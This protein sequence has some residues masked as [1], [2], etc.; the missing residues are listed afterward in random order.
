MLF[1]AGFQRR[2]RVSHMSTYK[3]VSSNTR[4]YVGYVAMILE[5]SIKKLQVG[6]IILVSLNRLMD[7]S[8]RCS[9]AKKPVQLFDRDIPGHRLATILPLVI[10]HIFTSVLESNQGV[11]LTDAVIRAEQERALKKVVE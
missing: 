2:D 9:S 7:K 4:S 10:R 1:D 11:R 5:I 8:T 3:T 6:F